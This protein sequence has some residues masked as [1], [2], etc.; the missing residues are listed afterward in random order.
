MGF[1]W[2]LLRM[3]LVL[4]GLL[5]MSDVAVKQRI[6][7]A[8]SRAAVGYD[9]VCDL[10]VGCGRRLL[11]LAE[12]F[13]RSGGV[14]CAVD[15]GCGTGL[16]S[17]DLRQS[18]VFARGLFGLDLSFGMVLQA[19]RL[20]F[21]VVCG[22]MEVLP[23]QSGCAD[24]VFSNFSCQWVFSFADFVGELSRVLVDDGL[25]VFS[26]PGEGSLDELRSSWAQVDP[27]RHVN[28]FLSAEEVRR[29]LGERG[30]SVRHFSV[31]RFCL[32]YVDLFALRAHLK[33]MGA[34]SVVGDGGRK[35]MVSRQQ[36][37]DLQAAY[38]GFR[39]DGLLP[40]S[41]DVFFVVAEK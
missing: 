14:E 8:F 26:F 18:P 23:F 28:V 16:L 4:F 6:A 2:I 41:F 35:G 30:F 13:V 17:Q 11:A 37:L 1:G 19:Q 40:L 38:E 22:D 32:Q 20:G 12:P 39:E 10:Q 31:E 29:V 3:W 34:W 25:L 21:P 36:W 33:A 24:F 15:V 27:F 7:R 5:V 9:E